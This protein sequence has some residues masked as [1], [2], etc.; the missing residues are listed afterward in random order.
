MPSRGAR[1]DPQQRPHRAA[2]AEQ[3]ALLGR[4]QVGEQVG[5]VLPQPLEIGLPALDEQHHHVG[6]AGCLV[7]QPQAD[8]LGVGADAPD[9]E[10][11]RLDLQPGHP[12]TQRLLEPRERL[13]VFLRRRGRRR[14]RRC[15]ER[16]G[17]QGRTEPGEHRLSPHVYGRGLSAFPHGLGNGVV[18]ARRI[19]PRAFLHRRKH[20]RLLRDRGVVLVDLLPGMDPVPLALGEGLRTPRARSAAAARRQA[21]PAGSRANGPSG[22]SAA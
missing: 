19:R 16:G 7:G 2:F 22:S 1:D 14:Q 17:A 11:G 5:P 20:A 3:L 13:F 9:H 10:L 4:R 15:G 6:L 18:V 12:G 8:R 21:A